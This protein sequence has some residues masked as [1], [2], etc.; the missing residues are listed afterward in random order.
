[1]N[2]LSSILT[3]MCILPIIGAEF[4]S[5]CYF[6]NWANSRPVEK[7]RFTIEDINPY[8]C[9]HLI[10]AF[11]VI[12]TDHTLGAMSSGETE[13][14]KKFNDLK[15]KNGELKTLL[16]V[17]GQN[18]KSKTFAALSSKAQNIE[19]FAKTSAK[20]L[21]DNGFD[22]IDVD[23]EYPG[24]TE[25]TKQQFTALLRGLREEFERETKESGKPRL[26]ISIA[27]PAGKKR[28]HDGYE[29]EQISKY[30]DYINIMAYDYF[31]PWNKIA[32]FNSPL[33]PR[34][35]DPRF[36]DQLN[37]KWS[38]GEWLRNKAHKEKIVVGMTGA[39]ASFTLNDSSVFD[40]GATVD[41]G[42]TTGTLYLIEGRLVYPEICEM[43][44]QG[45]TVK[46]DDEQEVPYAYKGNQ[47]V[48][49]DDTRS[50][51]AKV[52]WMLAEGYAGAMFWSMDFDDF[53]GNHCGKGKFPLLTAMH[54]EIIKATKPNVPTVTPD[55]V[56]YHKPGGDA[57]QLVIC[58]F[59]LCIASFIATVY[60]VWAH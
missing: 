5:L 49:Y 10:Y 30:V 28:I 40:V 15:L 11:A 22:G 17:G 24:E 59:V 12:K 47:W 31:G 21:R 35:S 25:N 36:S 53:A 4:V 41:G 44:K 48:G 18:A 8:L 46:Y 6:T 26:I 54:N 58:R 20:F 33:N 50:I 39:G 13:R 7:V 1:M 56:L 3:W 34:T 2:P 23:W 51:Q 27:A 32:G 45:A 42:G 57:S 37:Q 43:I 16:S 29:V 38:V 14:Y 19:H 52:K 55:A 60:I 9:S